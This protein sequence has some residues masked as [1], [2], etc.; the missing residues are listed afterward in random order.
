MFPR[1]PELPISGIS[2]AV[3]AVESMVVDID[4]SKLPAETMAP[5]ASPDRGWLES[6]RDLLCGV[7]VI[8]TS[9]DTLPNNLVDE[10]LTAQKVR[11]WR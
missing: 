1:K 10:F 2:S 6:S 3:P 7:H 8:E 4:L 11:E 9:M 5:R